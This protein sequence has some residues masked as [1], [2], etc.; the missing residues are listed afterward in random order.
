MHREYIMRYPRLF[1]DRTL[2]LVWLLVAVL[3]VSLALASI[4]PYVRLLTTTCTGAQCLAAHLNEAEAV[5]TTRAGWPLTAAT[6][7]LWTYFTLGPAVIALVTAAWA[8]WRRFRDPA[9]EP[10]ATL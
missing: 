5:V 4:G 7:R 3:V 9:E 10:S 6:A 1:T 8:I 2:Q